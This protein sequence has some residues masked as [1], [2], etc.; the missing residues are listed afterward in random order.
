MSEWLAGLGTAAAGRFS[1]TPKLDGCAIA[2]E[3]RLGLLT[4]AWTR[5]GADAMHLLPLVD[6]VPPTLNAPISVQIRGELYGLD[7]RQ[8]TPAASLRR[9][10]PSGEGLVFAAFEVMQSAAD[11]ATQLLALERW[12]LPI[13]PYLL[14]GAPQLAHHHR[15]W[16]QGQLWSELPTDGLVVQLDDG[17]QRRR[18]GV[19]TVAPRYALALKR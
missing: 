16:L 9:K 8:S 18:L 17:Q 6:T 5:S 4:A 13:P 11:H 7:G 12:G 19:T 3:Y 1:V 14:C 15:S 10:V 2:L